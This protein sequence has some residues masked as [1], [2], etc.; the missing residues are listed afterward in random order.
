MQHSE[1]NEHRPVVLVIDDEPSNLAVANRVLSREFEVRVANSGA[2]GISIAHAQRPHAV[3]LDVVMPGMDG[4]ETCQRL[5]SLPGMADVPVLF[6]TARSSVDDEERGFAA[7]AVDY[8]H[9]PISP[10]L[11]LARVR[12]QLR[13]QGALLN[14]R[15]EKQRGD[16]LLEVLLPTHVARELQ[17][18]GSFE[19]RRIEQATVLFA[20]LVGFTKWC[21]RHPPEEVVARLHALFL[22]LEAELHKFGLLKLKTIGDCLMAVIQHADNDESAR[23]AALRCG[24][25]MQAVQ[26]LAEYDWELRVGIHSGPLVAGIVGGDRYQYDVWGDTVNVAS[27]LTGAAEAGF[28]CMFDS[29]FAAL[30]GLVEEL[31]LDVRQTQRE[32]KGRGLHELVQVRRR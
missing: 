27:R 17:T 28:V 6:L 13:L 10:P 26:L 14:A 19:P 22:R 7:G 8:I 23:L 16:R 3:V 18:S 25:A 4:Y 5:R 15:G 12:T 20:D 2:R 32:L 21:A 11:L 24:L 9:K 30:S 1:L 31:D 29:D